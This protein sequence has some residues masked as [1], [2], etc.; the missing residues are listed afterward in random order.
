MTQRLRFGIFLAPWG[1]AGATGSIAGQIAKIKGCRVIGTAG[2][3]D[4]CDWLANEAHFE[5][6]SRRSILIRGS[7]SRLSG[8]VWQAISDFHS[9]ECPGQYQDQNEKPDDQGIV[10]RKLFN[11]RPPAAAALA[12]G[13]GHRTCRRG[14][15]TSPRTHPR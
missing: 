3:K 13:S 1:A 5:W 8:D 6:Q 4:K 10:R 14:P 15:A 12:P 11:L 7:S 2:G 9:S